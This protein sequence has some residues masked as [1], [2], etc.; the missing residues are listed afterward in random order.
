MEY[1]EVEVHLPNMREGLPCPRNVFK[2]F[3]GTV[4]AQEARAS[5][6]AAVQAAADGIEGASI[7]IRRTSDTPYTVEYVPVP[8]REVAGK[9]R[10]VPT[11]WIENGCDV[12]SEFIEY[13]RPLVG[14]LPQVGSL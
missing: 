2:C 10:T 3:G 4:D 7:T 9:T 13:A 1:V 6:R 12:T 5:G 11:S 8:L 14:P